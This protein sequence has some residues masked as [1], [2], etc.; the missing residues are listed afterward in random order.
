[1]SRPMRIWR[2]SISPST[3]GVT[4]GLRQRQ[5][6]V[7]GGGGRRGNWTKCFWLEE[8][9]VVSEDWVVR[10]Q[11]RLLQLERQSQQW[12]PAKSRVLVREKEVGE[13]AIHYRGQRL[14]FRELKADFIALVEVTVACP[15]LRL[16]FP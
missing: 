3:T 2:T 7:T 4:R 13:V 6:I 11:S 14:A 9:R 5:P 8:E 12:A 16:P 10:Y 15:S 1:M